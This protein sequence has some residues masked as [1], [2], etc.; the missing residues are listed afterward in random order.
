MIAHS[1]KGRQ[2]YCSTKWPFDEKFWGELIGKNYDRMYKR[3]GRARVRRG[4][5]TLLDSTHAG[6]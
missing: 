6:R 2:A 4:R 1:L 5:V 3:F